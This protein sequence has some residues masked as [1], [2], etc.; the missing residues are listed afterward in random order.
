MSSSPIALIRGDSKVT[1][2]RGEKGVS[3][4]RPRDRRL[5][6]SEVCSSEV[7]RRRGGEKDFG[8]VI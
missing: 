8:C 2:N 1:K 5:C 4:R 3:V 6:S 7:G